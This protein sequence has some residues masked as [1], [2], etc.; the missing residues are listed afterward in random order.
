MLAGLVI[1]GIADGSFW[2]TLLSPTIGYRPAVLFGLTLIFG[3]RGFLWSQLLLLSSFASFVAWPSA[4][5]VAVLYLISQGCALAVARK[6]AGAE[7]WLW[8]ER[9]TLGFLAAAFLAPAVPALLH[10]TILHAVGIAFRPGF[11]D[12]VDTWLRGGAGI[13]ALSPAIVVNGSAR[14]RQWA[15][16]PAEREWRQAITLRNVWE[17]AAET[18]LWIATFSITVTV[19]RQYG[20]NV[21]YLTFLPPLVFTLFRGMRFATLALA[22]NAVVATSLWYVLHWS[23]FISAAD[24]RLLLVIYSITI[25]VLAA[26]VEERRRGNA[27]VERL[28]AAETA[29]RA[30]EENFKNLANSAPV[31]LW[32]IGIDKLCKFANKPWL[33]FTG[34]RLEEKIGKDWTNIL[35]PDDVAVVGAAFGSAFSARG[36]LQIECRFRRGDGEYRW[37]LARGAPL[38]RA[39]AFDGFIGSCVDITEQKL[40]ADALRRSEAQLAYGQQLTKVGSF[41]RDVETGAMQWSAEKLR[42]L[43]LPEPPVS[44]AAVLDSINPN[45]REKFL[46]VQDRLRSTNGPHEVTYRIMRPSGETRM[47][48]SIAE[49]IR[50]AEGA[51]VRI[52]GASQDIT[53]QVQ[54]EQR[55]RESEELLRSAQQLAHVGSWHWDLETNR[56]SCS[57]ECIRILGQP[58][59]YYPSLEDFLAIVTTGDRERTARD[60]KASLLRGGLTTEFQ[61][62]RPNGEV[63]TVSFASRVV[64]NEQGLPRHVFGACHDVTDMRRAQEKAFARQK[65]ETVGTLANGVAHDFNNLL[66]SILAQ[67]ELALSELP[68][69]ATPQAQLEA[70]RDISVRGSDIVRELMIYAGAETPEPTLLDVSSVVE[71]MLALLKVSTSR[72]AVIQPVLAK[73][74]PAVRANPAR[75]SRIVMNLV[76]NASEAIGDQNGVIGVTT[77]CDGEFVQLEV[78]DTGC[79]MPAEVQ[80]RVF[81]PFF[82]TKSAGRGL[83]LALVDGI[84]RNLGGSIQFE[85]TLGTGTKIRISLPRVDSGPREVEAAVRGESEPGITP[86]ATVLFVEDEDALRRAVSKMLANRGISVIEAVD[87]S[88]ALEFVRSPRRIDILLLDVT[89]PGA[90]SREVFEEARRLRPETKVVIASAYTHEIAESSFQDHI[91]YFLRKPY[92]MGDLLQLIRQ[93]AP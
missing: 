21:T 90:S 10:G 27:D 47:V 48:R 4:I 67:T 57:E 72:N 20:L 24:L 11:I 64:F 85:S 60:I 75:I 87:G 5:F 32:I 40:A 54:A 69:G 23:E 82:S 3:W 31:M 56:A 13:L 6:F 76:T 18:L 25:L 9:S 37:M 62:S 53:D 58:D 73:N 17:L 39:G 28:A 46:Q 30:S 15:G 36:N 61:I 49:G 80:T 41:E 86:A 14:L 7:P 65:L 19:K 59:N 42:I 63:R 91:E 89:I 71:D 79:G 45:D 29:L 22:M 66:A 52:I 16:L 35:H 2:K 26:V 43:G 92:H 8:K 78:S 50:D 88:A 33:D 34:Y 74:L 55:L 38:Y 68:S 83:G 77:R 81:E 93:I 12:S 84:V 1:F 51:L 70:I 44:P